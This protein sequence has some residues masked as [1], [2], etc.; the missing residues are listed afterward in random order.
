MGNDQ[1]QGLKLKDLQLVFVPWHCLKPWRPTLLKLVPH[2]DVEQGRLSLLARTLLGCKSRLEDD[3]YT[4]AVAPS[5]IDGPCFLSFVEFC[6]EL[7]TELTWS[8]AVLNLSHRQTPFVNSAGLAK[9]VCSQRTQA[10][11]VWEA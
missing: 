3:Y 1:N 11:F 7:D 10:Y 2:T 5:S 6:E 4:V 8:V 9:L